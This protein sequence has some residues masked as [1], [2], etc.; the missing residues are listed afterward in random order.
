MQSL[1]E[2]SAK[3]A[4]GKTAVESLKSS[5]RYLKTDFKVHLGMDDQ[6]AD[7]C[8]V[9]ALSDIQEPAYHTKWDHEHDLHR[10]RCQILSNV[11]SGVQEKINRTEINI[12]MLLEITAEFPVENFS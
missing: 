1:C 7:H 6:C 10:D 11:L 5:K 12:I 8:A 9:H 2:A 4:W 3:S